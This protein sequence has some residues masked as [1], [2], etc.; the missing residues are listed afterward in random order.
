MEER[1]LARLPARNVKRTNLKAKG[2]P[3]S[4]SEDEERPDSFLPK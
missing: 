2:E 4:V 1:A 3:E